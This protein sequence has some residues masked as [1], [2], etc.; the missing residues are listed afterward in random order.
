MLQASIR[1]GDSFSGVM[2]FTHR[3][4]GV[5]VTPSIVATVAH[6]LHDQYGNYFFE[7]ATYRVVIGSE[8]SAEDSKFLLVSDL[9]VHRR[10][11]I[12]NKVHD[13][14]MLKL[15]EP[16]SIVVPALSSLRSTN[17]PNFT[18]CIFYGWIFMTGDDVIAGNLTFMH[19]RTDYKNKP[20]C[21]S[22]MATSQSYIVPQALCFVV[23]RLIK[24]A[25]LYNAGA[26]VFCLDTVVGLLSY[27]PVSFQSETTDN[28]ALFT[29]ISDYV[30]LIK[31]FSRQSSSSRLAGIMKNFAFVLVYVYFVKIMLFRE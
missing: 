14:A 19:F 27:M 29:L 2:N 4:S 11:L 22:E 3:C 6:C 5:L 10:Y 13:F 15:K 26:P 7:P 28:L 23:P 21:Y 8:L 12:E 17:L 20:S 18:E 9:K 24:C 16:Q 30:D 31:A 25:C 1:H